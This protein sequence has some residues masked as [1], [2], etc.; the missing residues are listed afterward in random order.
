MKLSKREK[1]LLG[2]LA[3]LLIII[4]GVMGLLKP[5]WEAYTEAKQTLQNTQAKKDEIQMMLPLLADVEDRLHTEEARKWKE[6]FFYRDLEDVFIDRTV[7]SLAEENGVSLTAV[8]IDD[9]IL[10]AVL[11]FAGAG[12]FVAP[13]AETDGEGDA[14]ADVKNAEDAQDPKADEEPEATAPEHTMPLYRCRVEGVG[15]ESACVA[16]LAALNLLGQSGYVSEFTITR[17]EDLEGGYTGQ[18]HLE[19][20][21]QFYFLQTDT[22]GTAET[23]TTEP[24][25]EEPA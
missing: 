19:A 21:L 1:I 22:G 25:E 8:F 7:S 9:P 17:Q 12:F 23:D 11:P 3:F 24:A 6:A 10:G 16:Y 4:G 20:T 5:T 18:Y 15:S 13:E 14:Y 2:I